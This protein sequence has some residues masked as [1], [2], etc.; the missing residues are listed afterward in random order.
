MTQGDVSLLA[1]PVAQALLASAQ[2][3]HLAYQWSDGSPRVVPIWFQWNGEE[4]VMGTPPAA[5]KLKVLR[6]GDPV[7]ITIDSRDWPYQVLYVRGNAEISTIKGVVAE[8]AL[9]AAKYLGDL[10]GAVWVRQFPQGVRMTRIA[11]RPTW[12]GVLDFTTRFPSAMQV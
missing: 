2:L 1:D 4:V 6:D 11:V 5:P 8:Y 9:A 10:Q 3:A 12:V 7:A